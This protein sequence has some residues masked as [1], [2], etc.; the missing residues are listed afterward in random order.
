M[1]ID[2]RTNQN[3]TTTHGTQIEDLRNTAV[4][5]QVP[6][7]GTTGLMSTQETT[8]VK[9]TASQHHV[10]GTHKTTTIQESTA[11]AQPMGHEI[12]SSTLAMATTRPLLVPMGGAVQRL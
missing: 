8:K 5:I 11:L 1:S 6:I 10:A 12:V 3:G 7:I 4:A 9:V 2:P